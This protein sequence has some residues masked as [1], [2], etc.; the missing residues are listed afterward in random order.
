MNNNYTGTLENEDGMTNTTAAIAS[1]LC[2][3]LMRELDGFRHEVEMFP[4][5]ASLWKVV[6]GITNSAGTLAI[7][8]AGNLRSMIGVVLG[9][10]GYVR[11][12]D[13]EFSRRGLTREEVKAELDQAKNEI[14]PVMRKLNDAVLAA[15]YPGDLHGMTMPTRRFLIANEVHAAFH[16]GQAG[17]IRRVVTGNATS[18]HPIETEPLSGG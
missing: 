14:E 18:S 17:Y 16:L 7:H 12:R 1:D 5:D 15:P 6:P 10:S 3:M 11:N 13:A 8:V 9:G 4:D 2:R